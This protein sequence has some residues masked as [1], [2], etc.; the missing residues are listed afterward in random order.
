MVAEFPSNLYHGVEVS[1]RP[2]KLLRSEAS[3]EKE[4]FFSLRKHVWRLQVE[5]PNE[6]VDDFL[7]KL[8]YLTDKIG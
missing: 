8:S 2:I 6:R 7:A 3:D 4:D 1:M 5:V